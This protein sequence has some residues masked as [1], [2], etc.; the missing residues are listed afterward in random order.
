MFQTC[1]AAHHYGNRTES[2]I[3]P[4][5]LHCIIFQPFPI[6]TASQAQTVRQRGGRCGDAVRFRSDL[7]SIFQNDASRKTTAHTHTRHHPAT[8]AYAYFIVRFRAI[9][10]PISIRSW[11]FH[12]TPSMCRPKTNGGKRAFNTAPVVS[13]IFFSVHFVSPKG[14]VCAGVRA[15]VRLW[16]HSYSVRMEGF[17]H[18]EAA[19]IF[20][21]DTFF[22]QSGGL[23]L[24]WRVLKLDG[25]DFSFVQN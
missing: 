9:L 4:Q 10:N 19:V 25:M 24:V 6:P 14:G 12:Q 13:L 16:A 1:G 21:A 17:F 8:H 20:R 15:F 23:S 2:F 22:I 7:R 3:F 5:S 18:F 11:S